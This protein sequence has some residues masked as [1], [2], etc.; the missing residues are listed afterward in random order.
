[1]NSHPAI[2]FLRQLDARNETSF[3]IDVYAEAPSDEQKPS[4]NEGMVQVGEFPAPFKLIPVGQTSGWLLGDVERWLSA[5]A[6]E[7]VTNE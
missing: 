4:T 2:L 5:R 6:D 1:M 3:N 7:G